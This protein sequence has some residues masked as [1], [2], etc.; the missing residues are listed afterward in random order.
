VCQEVTRRAKTDRPQF[1]RLLVG[2]GPC[3]AVRVTQL[4]QLAR[5]PR[6][7]LNT[8]ATISAKEADDIQRLVA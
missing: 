1:R 8:L 5:E 2:I 3:D 4:D 6:E 7:F